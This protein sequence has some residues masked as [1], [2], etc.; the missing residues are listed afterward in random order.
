MNVKGSGRVGA[1]FV[2]SQPREFG[3]R[4]GNHWNVGFSSGTDRIAGKARC[5]MPFRLVQL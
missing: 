2:L 4:S 3:E 1:R 5:S